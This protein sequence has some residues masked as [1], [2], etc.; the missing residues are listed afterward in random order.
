MIAVITIAAD[1]GSVVTLVAAEQTWACW[2]LGLPWQA[3]LKLSELGLLE[4]LL[5]GPQHSSAGAGV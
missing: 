5:K 2:L 3:L 4:H 1:S